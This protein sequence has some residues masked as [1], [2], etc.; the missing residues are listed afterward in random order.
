MVMPLG[1]PNKTYPPE[2]PFSFKLQETILVPYVPTSSVNFLMGGPPLLWEFSRYNSNEFTRNTQI[3]Q[4]FFFVLGDEYF[5]GFQQ[6][7]LMYPNG[8]SV[9]FGQSPYHIVL[10]IPTL[11][12]HPEHAVPVQ[13]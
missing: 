12:P 7:S 10:W 6:C 4:L 1:I 11:S 9:R 8:N 5:L 2:S 13:L 3:T